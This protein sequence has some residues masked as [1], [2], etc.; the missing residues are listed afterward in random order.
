MRKT[1]LCIGLLII[2]MAGSRGVHAQTASYHVADLAGLQ[3][4]STASFPLG[5]WRDS[6]ASGSSAPPLFYKPSG[7][8]CSLNSGAGDNGSQVSSSDGKCWLAAFPSEGRDIRQFGAIGDDTT[9]D[10]SAIQAAINSLPA[11]GGTILI[12]AL[13]FRTNSTITVGNG[14]STAPS[15]AQGV[16]LYGVG[17]P[18]EHPFG[19]FANSSAPAIDYRG[20]ADA[21]LVRGPLQGW[22]V[23]NLRIQCQSTTGTIGLD[24]VSG[25]FGDSR[26]LSVV[27]CQFGLYSQTVSAKPTGLAN[28]DALHNTYENISI[29]VPDI[30]PVFGIAIPEVSTL[31]GTTDYNIFRNIVITFNVSCSAGQ[32]AYGLYLT[33]SDGNLWEDIHMAG[34]NGCAAPVVFDYTVSGSAWP[35]D[36]T[37]IHFDAGNINGSGFLNNGT[38]PSSATPQK[39]LSVGLTN[40]GSYPLNVPNLYSV[41]A[42]STWTPQ[43]AGSTTP[44]TAT[45]V[46]QLGRVVEAGSLVTLTFN[47]VTSN[48]SGAAGNMNVIGLPATAAN[49][50][51]QLGGCVISQLGGVALDSGYT[52]ATG[53]VY[54]NSTAIGLA[55]N[56]SG[57][58]QLAI[59][60]GNFA[61]GSTVQGSCTYYR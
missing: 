42:S 4:A 11:A 39:V 15:A 50:S 57:K 33:G 20:S 8:A 26:N 52:M 24:I 38:P 54:P 32:A 1:I 7:S 48:I 46:I 60:V 27:N 30:T 55:E 23:E 41:F 10:S 3:A 56:G 61:G 12:P 45:Y 31:V 36:N 25:Q 47:I 13:V 49:I 40:L 34:G 22:G 21:I 29:F 9:D 14:S 19:G 59:P 18:N 58:P 2:G 44:G 6:Y 17:V 53:V 16:K 51:N 35:D 43:L 28:V 5:L 37:F